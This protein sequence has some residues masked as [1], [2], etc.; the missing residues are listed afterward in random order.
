MSQGPPKNQS[1]SETRNEVV[2]QQQHSD[3]PGAS[4]MFPLDMSTPGAFH[5][6]SF[7]AA[8]PSYLPPVPNVFSSPFVGFAPQHP[9]TLHPYLAQFSGRSLPAMTPTKATA[10]DSKDQRSQPNAEGELPKV[11]TPIPDRRPLWPN[12]APGTFTQSEPKHS[13]L[14]SNDVARKAPRKSASSSPAHVTSL[15]TSTANS[16]PAQ[17]RKDKQE[18]RLRRDSA[19]LADHEQTAQSGTPRVAK[20][21][22]ATSRSIPTQSLS[23]LKDSVTPK[24]QKGHLPSSARSRRFISDNGDDEVNKEEDGEDDDDDLPL[25]KLFEKGHARTPIR[26]QE[27]AT[28]MKKASNGPR[29]LQLHSR[30]QPRYD[31]LV[32]DELRGVQRALGDDNW[33][34]YLILMEKRL[35]GEVTEVDFVVQSKAIFMVFDVKTRTRLEKQIA[36]TVVLPVIEQHKEHDVVLVDG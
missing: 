18:H 8:T 10:N 9:N 21:V 24:T 31:Y 36:N 29:E 6:S 28:R 17:R 14:P 20:S 32:P 2:P 13:R 27:A 3:F 22:A 16:K 35:M 15:R 34:D 1:H 4:Y 26:G 25:R 30:A 7:G 23:S 33:T 5:T 19:L 12:Y 11:Y